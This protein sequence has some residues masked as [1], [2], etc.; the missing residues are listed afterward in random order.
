[1]W[2]NESSE[3]RAETENPTGAPTQGRMDRDRGKQGWGSKPPVG[4]GGDPEA[5]A[6]HAGLTMDR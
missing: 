5:G 3:T 1:M 4:G 6:E 2:L